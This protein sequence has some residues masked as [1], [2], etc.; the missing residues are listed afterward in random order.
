MKA[1]VYFIHNRAFTYYYI[2]S[3][4]GL[5]RRLGDHRARLSNGTHKNRVMQ[6]AARRGI[7]LHFSIAVECPDRVEAELLEAELLSFH[8]G[9][10]GCMNLSSTPNA[11]DCP[12]RRTH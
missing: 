6:R 11:L 10:P 9:K 3:S 1:G 12:H 5:E 4:Q 7:K 2:G 8:F